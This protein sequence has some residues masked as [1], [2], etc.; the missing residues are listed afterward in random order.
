L[1]TNGVSKMVQIEG[2]DGL[3]LSDNYF[4]LVAGFARKIRVQALEKKAD[5]LVALQVS[6]LED[7][8]VEEVLLRNVD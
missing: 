8:F 5:D 3:I 7:D 1:T 6:S 2:A 4:P